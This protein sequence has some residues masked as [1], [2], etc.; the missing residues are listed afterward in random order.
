MSKRRVERH[1]AEAALLFG[2]LADQTRLSLVQRL[3]ERGPASISALSANFQISRQAITKHLRSLAA[4]GIIEGT[5]EGRE[6]VWALNPER[7]ADA[8]RCLDVIT[9]GWDH[10]LNRLKEHLEDRESHLLTRAAR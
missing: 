9:R 3:S 5:R 2:A 6:H 4:A 10:A 8:Q 7:L 1:L